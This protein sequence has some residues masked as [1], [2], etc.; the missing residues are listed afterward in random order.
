MFAMVDVGGTGLTG[1]AFAWR[2][3]D[4]EGVA[5]MPGSSFGDQASGHVRVSLSAEEAVL[6]EAAERMV[7]LAIR[8]TRGRAA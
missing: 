8:L 5:V 6:R 3:L 1:E 2:L 7:R 4:E